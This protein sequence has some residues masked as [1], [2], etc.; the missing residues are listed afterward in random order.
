M[1]SA[2]ILIKPFTKT[3]KK[4]SGIPKKFDH[5]NLTILDFKW[6]SIPLELPVV[7]SSFTLLT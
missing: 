3:L 5:L 6:L 4:I 7:R 2:R 1:I